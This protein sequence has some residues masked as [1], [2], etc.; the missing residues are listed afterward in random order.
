MC[1]CTNFV[2][3]SLPIKSITIFFDVDQPKNTNKDPLHVSNGLMTQSKKKT[4]KK[5]L[6][7]LILKISIKSEL[8]GPLEYQE[9]ILV[10]LIYVQEG[11]IQSY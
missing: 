2:T 6:N 11:P 5:T 7:A 10:H 8:Q 3:V 1:T 9:E 4:L